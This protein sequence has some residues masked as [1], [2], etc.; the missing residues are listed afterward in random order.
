VT[1]GIDNTGTTF[2]IAF[3]F[4]T[5]ESSKSFTFASEQLT[6]LCFYDCPVAA[7]MCGDFSKGLGASIALKATQDLFKEKQVEDEDGFVE[8]DDVQEAVEDLEI[9]RVIDLLEGDTT[10]VDVGVGSEGERTLLQLCE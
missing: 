1:V 5:S 7:I 10:I 9:Q 3:M 2:P 8:I 4:I 6:D